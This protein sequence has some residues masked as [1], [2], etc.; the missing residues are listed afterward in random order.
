M[1]W[2]VDVLREHVVRVYRAG[3]P[4]VPTI[5]QGGEAA[6]AELALPGWSMPVADLLP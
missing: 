6:E 3:D 2:N 4:D 1:V 5:Y